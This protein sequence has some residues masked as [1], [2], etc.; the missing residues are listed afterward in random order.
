MWN[1]SDY[2]II[3]LLY[4]PIV[5]NLRNFASDLVHDIM[6]G[7]HRRISSA[8][9]LFKNCALEDDASLLLLLPSLILQRKRAVIEKRLDPVVE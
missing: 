6:Y 2:L 5:T 9:S 8:Q 7:L 1:V 4:L 3:L